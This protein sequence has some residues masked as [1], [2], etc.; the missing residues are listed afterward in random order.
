[1]T[2]SISTYIKIFFALA[3]VSIIVLYT[4]SKSADFLEGPIIIIHIPENGITVN[5]SLIEIRG[6]AEH[7]SHISLNGKKIFVN[8]EGL[9]S[10]QLLLSPGY[11]IITLEARDRFDREVKKSL[12]LVYK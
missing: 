6:T 9:F 10:E 3:L 11:N 12:E 7:I 2:Q 1:M 4:Y 5:R 8:E